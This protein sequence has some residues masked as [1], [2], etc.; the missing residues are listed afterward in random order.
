MVVDESH[1]YRGVFG[2]QVAAVL[3]RLRRLAAHYGADPT[4]AVLSATAADPV[5]TAAALTGIAADDLTL[6]D[7]DGSARGADPDQPG[8]ARSWRRRP[9]PPS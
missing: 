9:P 1:R 3:R 4:F 5:A 7:D 8:R 6:V 2:A